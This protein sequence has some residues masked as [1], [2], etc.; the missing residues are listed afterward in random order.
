VHQRG[1]ELEEAAVGQRWPEEEA[2]GG[3]G[4]GDW[5]RHDARRSRAGA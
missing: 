5:C 4:C 3:A 1:V 2:L